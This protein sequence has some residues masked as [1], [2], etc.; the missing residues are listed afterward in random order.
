MNRKILPSTLSPR[1]PVPVGSNPLMAAALA[2]LLGATACGNAESTPTGT[3]AA[4]SDDTSSADVATDSSTGTADATADVGADAT[5]EPQIISVKKDPTMK[6]ATFKDLCQKRGGLIQTHAACSGNNACKG[7]S[8]NKFSLDMIEHTCKALNS[9]GGMSCVELPVDTGVSGKDTY[10][11]HCTDCHG[12]D[13]FA[14]FVP[15]GADLTKANADFTAKP[16]QRQ[17]L[18]TA[19]GTSGV[20]DSGTAYHNMPAFHEKL[21]KGEIERTV[22]YIRALGAK[23]EHY[24]IVG[25]T[26]DITAT[27]EMP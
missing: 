15:P 22:E 20:N 7:F 12:K 1:A 10:A 13:A 2:G 17:V 21:S 18:I 16:A 5:T 14:L 23:A 19:F 6:F 25:E 4:C 3:T 9:C 24:G 11:A 26:E 27:S 8:F